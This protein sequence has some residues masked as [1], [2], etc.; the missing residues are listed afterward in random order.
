[1]GAG[2]HEP[3]GQGARALCRVI[4][5]E[6]SLPGA[7]LAIGR[8]IFLSQRPACREDFIAI[9]AKRLGGGAVERYG[10]RSNPAELNKRNAMDNK[11]VIEVLNKLLENELAGVVRYTHYSFMVFGH[12]RIPIVAWLRAQANESLD[13]ANQAGEQITALGG[14]PSLKIAPLLES[15][16]HSIDDIMKESLVHEKEQLETFKS[17]LAL[18]EG[19]SIYLEEYA[20]GMIFDEQGHISEVEKMIRKE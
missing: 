2:L 8:R 14:H 16:K 19:K 9:F 3:I 13:H 17:L 12:T 4:G 5:A 10:N 15:E 20:R 11:R 1:M 7:A 18:V 6:T